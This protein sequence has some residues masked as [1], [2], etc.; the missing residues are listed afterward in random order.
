VTEH[1]IREQVK[2]YYERKLR[3]H[4]PT[5]AGVDWNSVQSQELRFAQFERLWRHEPEAS[6]LDYGCGYGAL[7]SFLRAQGHRGEYVGFDLSEEMIGVARRE[8]EAVP[9]CRFT[10]CRSEV[11]PCDY[12]V[13]SGVFNVKQDVTDEGWRSFVDATVADLASL[14]SRGFAFNALTEYSD[15]DRR[16]ADLY[17][18][19][20]LYWFDHCKRTYGQ[21]VALLHDYPLW[22]FTIIVRRH[23]A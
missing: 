12:V 6:V 20:P 21:A 2:D 10:A 7:A 1:S 5:P 13:A 17:Y 18:A 9:A 19:N 4:G 11:T 8:A 23:P 15:A 16:R 3:M 14:A 22:E